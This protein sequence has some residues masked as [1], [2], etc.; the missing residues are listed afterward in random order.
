MSLAQKGGAPVVLTIAGSD[1][2]GGAG[3][4]ADLRTFALHGVH[5]ASV[6]TALTAQNTVGV[7]GIKP[8]PAEFVAR[9]LD[10]V[11]SDLSPLAIKT[12]M[13]GPPEL[14]SA[15]VERLKNYEPNWLVVDPVL[16]ATSGDRLLPTMSEQLIREL[17]IPM[18]SLVTP[19]IRE[20]GVLL[21]RRV[22]LSRS[23]REEA[24]MHLYE[25]FDVPVLV[26]GGHADDASDVLYAD[27]EPTW[28]DGEKIE[29]RHTHGTGCHLSAAIAARLAT[30]EPLHLAIRGAK[31]WL[32][33]ALQRSRAIG[34]G[35]SPPWPGPVS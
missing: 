23:A 28:F 22:Y 13:L 33:E 12:G 4:Q 31:Q 26:K 24:A 3:I 17:L 30:G 20:A 35:H 29:T 19:N 21:G 16:V 5:G 14:I 27:G 34:R 7:Q 6:I 2:S 18:A 9:Q 25:Q 11:L 10:S 1:P 8:I 15:V 32:T